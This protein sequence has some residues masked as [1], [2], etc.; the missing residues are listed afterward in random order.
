MSIGIAD[1]IIITDSLISS[2]R[3]VFKTL[4]QPRGNI[5]VIIPQQIVFWSNSEIPDDFKK[6][7]TGEI[8]Q[9][10]LTQFGIDYTNG[11]FGFVRFNEVDPSY[12]DTVEAFLN[13]SNGG[14]MYMVKH[15]DAITLEVRYIYET[16]YRTVTDDVSFLVFNKR[17]ELM[18]SF[19]HT[20][21][22]L[23][24]IIF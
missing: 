12:L 21:F 2:I 11:E 15:Y 10:L 23:R 16:Y 1:D 14:R 4:F 19:V 17:G 8:A 13:N 6:R 3:Y 18:P 9:F 5:K 20:P 22:I 24:E 7:I